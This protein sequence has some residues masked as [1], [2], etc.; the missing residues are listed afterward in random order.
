MA[1]EVDISYWKSTEVDEIADALL[2]KVSDKKG[3]WTWKIEYHPDED[4]ES[5]SLAHWTLEGKSRKYKIS[6]MM[7]LGNVPWTTRWKLYFAKDGKKYSCSEEMFQKLPSLKRLEVKL[8]ETGRAIK[9]KEDAK[10]QRKS[11]TAEREYEHIER[12]K[13]K[14][15]IR[16]LKR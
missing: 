3:G 15:V 16:S 6:I 11:E 14:S 8:D 5:I 12:R 1:Q 10:A 2:Q 9:K 13:A 4:N 7:Y